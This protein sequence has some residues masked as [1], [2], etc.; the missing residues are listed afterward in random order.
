MRVLGGLAFFGAITSVTAAPRVYPPKQIGEYIV[1]TT[2]IETGRHT[3][4]LVRIEDPARGVVCY[5]QLGDN[6]SCV[7]VRDVSAVPVTPAPEPA[8]ANPAQ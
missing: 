7:R 1:Q 5:M 4:W 2:E 6:M 8:P 3:T